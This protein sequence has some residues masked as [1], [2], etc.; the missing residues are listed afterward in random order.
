M[1]IQVPATDTVELTVTQLESG[2]ADAIESGALGEGVGSWRLRIEGE[3]TVMSLL[4]AS[5]GH[6][7][8]L[9]RADVARGTGPLPTA[10]LPPPATVTLESVGERQLRARWDRIEGAR[11]DVDVLK[12]GVRQEHLSLLGTR[13]TAIRWW[14]RN[15]AGTYSLQVRSVNSDDVRGPWSALS[16]PIVFN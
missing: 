9:S 10:L 12:N 15:A 4:S 5:S 1:R 6:L 16:N 13:S 2:A 11:Y 7:T 8:N 3:V 14:Y